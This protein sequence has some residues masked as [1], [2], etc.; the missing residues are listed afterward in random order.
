MKRG[1]VVV[2]YVHPTDVSAFFHESLVETMMRDAQGP[3]RIV[4]RLHKYSSA[5]I[6]NARNA[7][8][9]SFLEQS[10]AEWLWMVDTDMHWLPDDLDELLKYASLERAPVLGGLCFGVED[11]VLFPTLYDFEQRDG[12]VGTLRYNEFPENAV[13][14]VGATGAAFLLIHRKVLEAVRDKAFNPTYPWFQ[15]TELNGSACGEDVTFCI[16]A[17]MAGFPVHVHTGVEIGHHKSHVLTAGQYLAQRAASR[18]S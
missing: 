18:E 16:R 12:G 17:A 5:N 7:I 13:F 4:G 8:V 11:G 6:S 10:D 2:G 9:R 14:Q 1:K 3:R 15:E